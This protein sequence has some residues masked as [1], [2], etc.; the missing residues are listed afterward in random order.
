MKI[1]KG[2]KM[3]NDRYG[4]EIPWLLRL[5]GCWGICNGTYRMRWGE[6]TIGWSLCLGY[7]VYH[8][9]GTINISPLFFS[10]YL[11]APMLITQRP[12]TEDYCARFGIWYHSRAFQFTWRTGCKIIYLPW[13][14]DHVR[15]SYLW[16]DGRVHHHAGRGEYDAP[17]VIKSIHPY[18]YTRKNGDTQKRVATIYGDEREWRWKGFKWLPWPRKVRRCIEIAFSDEIGEGVGSWKGGTVGCGYEWKKDET[19]R[20]ALLRMERDRTFNA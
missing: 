12:G 10:L 3:K 5:I 17:L 14:W 19:Q 7:S 9:R 13:D 11:R 6:F 4:K 18:T 2:K 20:Q 15:H 1:P 8:D 16:P